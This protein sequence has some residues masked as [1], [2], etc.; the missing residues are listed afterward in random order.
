MLAHRFLT[1]TILAALCAVLLLTAVV[2]AQTGELEFFQKQ[3]T[4]KLTVVQK[5]ERDAQVLLILTLMVLALGAVTAA[6]QIIP[7]SWCKPTCVAIGGIISI[8]T[9][10]NSYEFDGDRRTLRR[11]AM[12][13]HEIMDSVDFYMLQYASTD[14]PQ[15]RGFWVEQMRKRFGE[16]K[17]LRGSMG[18]QPEKHALN[19]SSGFVTPAYAMDSGKKEYAE[20]YFSG[21][22]ESGDLTTAKEYAELDARRQAI[23]YLQTYL[24]EKKIADDSL[25][26][27]A[28]AEYLVQNAVFD[29][30]TF[31]NR[32]EAYRYTSRMSFD[33]TSLEQDIHF[34]ALRKQIELKPEQVS[35]AVNQIEQKSVDE[36]LSPQRQIYLQDLDLAGKMLLASQFERYNEAVHLI[37]EENYSDAAGT[38]QELADEKPDYP[39]IWL[40]LGQLYSEL[41]KEVSARKALRTANE[42]LERLADSSIK[43]EVR[44]LYDAI[45]GQQR[46]GR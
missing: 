8:L 41:G 12:E 7:K 17:A 28:L 9:Y 24:K 43:A 38:L 13:G 27:T 30:E 33:L 14:K 44:S 29:R 6:L 25:D 32:G 19:V 1:H 26:P 40:R 10:F 20:V 42:R 2:S 11:K 34:Y 4:D 22:G 36:Y 16:F 45:A 23:E 37:G 5:W 15:E 35:G 21:I 3:R 46:A 18:G 39:I 31:E